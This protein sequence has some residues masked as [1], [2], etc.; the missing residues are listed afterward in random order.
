MD[1][2]TVRTAMEA[3]DYTHE[4]NIEGEKEYVQFLSELNYI[5]VES[6]QHFVEQ[7][8]DSEPLKSVTQK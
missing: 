8:I 4:L 2:E 7:F 3:V 1:A 6:P 5:R